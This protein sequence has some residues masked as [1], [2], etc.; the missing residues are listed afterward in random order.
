MS[1]VTKRLKVGRHTLQMV[2]N[3]AGQQPFP[4]CLGRH[5]SCSKCGWEEAEDVSPVA[6]VQKCIPM[7]KGRMNVN[8]V[9]HAKQMPG[10]CAV[11]AQLYSGQVT[12]H[13]PINGCHTER[14]GWVVQP[15]WKRFTPNKA[16]PLFFFFLLRRV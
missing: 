8:L 5:L 15:L 13:V 6:P 7:E 2:I 11:L 10:D 4:S 1:K 12:K 14:R 16:Q 3:L 9:T